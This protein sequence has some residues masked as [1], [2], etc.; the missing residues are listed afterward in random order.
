ME[1]LELI[2]LV[3]CCCFLVELFM[4]VWALGLRYAMATHDRVL[5]LT[6]SASLNLGFD[7]LMPP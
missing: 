6:G 4:S 2:S 3:I 5:A 1:V 7:V